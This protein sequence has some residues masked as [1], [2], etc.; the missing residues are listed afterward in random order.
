MR[1]KL[2]FEDRNCE[3]VAVCVLLCVRFPPDQPCDG[4]TRAARRGWRSR[5]TRTPRSCCPSRIST[6]SAKSAAKRRLIQQCLDRKEIVIGGTATP[7]HKDRPFKK[8]WAFT[9]DGDYFA[10]SGKT[11]RNIY[12]SREILRKTMNC[13]TSKASKP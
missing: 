1:S 6:S 5:A 9:V 10:K 11:L 7:L 3:D 8:P 2:S 13:C 4:K 12:K